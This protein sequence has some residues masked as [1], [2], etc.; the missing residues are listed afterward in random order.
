MVSSGLDA[1]TGTFGFSGKYITKRLLGMGRKVLTLTGHPDREN[2]FGEAVSVLPF[3]FDRPEELARSL[4]GVDTLYNTYWIRFEYGGATYAKAVENSKVLVDAAARSGVRRIVHTSITNPSEDS[5]FPYFS[6]KAAVERHIVGSGLSYAILRPPVFFGPEGILINNIAWIL[7]RSPAFGIP[8]SGDYKLQ[9]IFVDDFAEIAV[10]M[11]EKSENVIL[12][13]AGPEIF[14][15]L[16]L[17]KLIAE[18]VGS[19]SRIVHLPPNLAL[20]AAEAIGRSVDDVVLTRDEVEGL[21]AGLLVSKQP[22]LGHTR[23]SDW[24]RENAESI[25]REYFSEVGRHFR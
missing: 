5:L 14:T 7:R 20:M 8:G 2:P 25:G 23:L 11:G 13:A 3:N 19:R 18:V 12:D 1:V 24:L 6:G 21:M 15:F 16:E 17:V 22:P 4:E 10:G 9:P